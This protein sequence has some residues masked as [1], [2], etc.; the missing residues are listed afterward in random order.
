M[1]KFIRGGYLLLYYI[2]AQ[3][4]PK[5]TFPVLGILGRRLRVF[6]C[7]RLF[8][9]MGKNI[10]IENNAYIGNGTKISIGNNSGIGSHFHVQGTNL[11]IGNHVMMGEEVLILG[12]GHCSDRLDIPMDQQGS[13]PPS[14]LK[15]CDDVW[16]GSRVTILGKVGRIGSGV[17][18][19]AGS[20][21]TKAIPDYAIVAGNP[22]KTI[23]FRNKNDLCKTIE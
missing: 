18:I 5:S 23:R 14:E 19:G 16:I 1:N 20:V 12:G 9:K 21:V 11:K 15:I 2:L 8:V 6:L 7:Q 4:L 13:L 22:A 17:I 3:H 10:N